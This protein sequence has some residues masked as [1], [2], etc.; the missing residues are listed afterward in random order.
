[1]ELT[2][3]LELR[4]FRQE[5]T[6][7]E[8]V[9]VRDHFLS[10]LRAGVFQIAELKPDIWHTAER[11]ARRHTA[12]LG[13]RTLDILHIAAALTLKPDA[14]LTFDERERKLARAERLRV[15]PR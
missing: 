15:L 9:A 2:N 13:T 5:L 10:D 6:R 14:F 1:M 7:T 3:A 12:R 11:L 8:A 4:V